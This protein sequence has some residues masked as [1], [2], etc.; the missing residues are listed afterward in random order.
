MAKED[1]SFMSLFLL[2]IF[3][4]F[5]TEMYLGNQWEIGS[6]IVVLL[7]L[8]SNL[9]VVNRK[10]RE[11]HL[12]DEEDRPI[13]RRV[14]WLKFN[15]ILICYAAVAGLVYFSTNSFHSYPLIGLK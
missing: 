13:H 1:L 2:Y 7:Y 4:F 5:V 8:L 3:L 11:L 9:A 10:F 12:L 6:V 15:G 14:I